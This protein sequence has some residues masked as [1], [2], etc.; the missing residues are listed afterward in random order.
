ER[1]GYAVVAAATPQAAL[2]VVSGDLR[3]DAA[4]IDVLLPGGDGI[5]LHRELVELAPWLRNRTVFLTGA[6]HDRT[7]HDAIEA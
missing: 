6:A 1:A 3:P 4:V 5:S 7:I 2:E